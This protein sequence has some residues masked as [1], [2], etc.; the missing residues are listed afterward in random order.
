[1]KFLEAKKAAAKAAKAKPLTPK[2]RR[3]QFYEDKA[4]HEPAPDYLNTEPEDQPEDEPETA[5]EWPM[6]LTPEAYLARYPEGQHA[7][8]ARK[9]L[10]GQADDFDAEAD[11]TA[12]S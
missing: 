4:L 8:L 10:D 5:D 3:A 7:D 1:M 6:T 12:D 9:I 2:A 11:E